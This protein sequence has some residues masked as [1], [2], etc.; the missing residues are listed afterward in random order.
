M[1]SARFMIVGAVG[2]GKTTLLN[3]LISRNEA[4]KKTQAIEYLSSCID[5][6]GEYLE[7]PFYYR[8]LFSTALEADGI[9]F[10]HDASCFSSAFPPGFA[11]AFSNKTLGVITKV[12]HPKANEGRA[13]EILNS[14]GLSEGI[15]AV[16]ALTG[17]GISS[18]KKH[19]GWD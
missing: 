6:P 18:L 14:L 17:Q 16:S 19:L 7:N 11:G 13:R 9:L 3:A 10:V 4:I 15:F 5:T 2:A 12:D 1:N 8:A